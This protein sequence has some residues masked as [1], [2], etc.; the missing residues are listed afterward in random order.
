MK[1]VIRLTENDLEKL[2]KRI[3]KEEAVAEVDRDNIETKMVELSDLFDGT[4]YSFEYEYNGP[5][6]EIYLEGGSHDIGITVGGG[7]VSVI[8]MMRG[9]KEST[10]SYQYSDMNEALHIVEKIIHKILNVNENYRR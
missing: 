7:K 5:D 2:V 3:I 9:R 1:K 8:E 6:L 10:S 4:N